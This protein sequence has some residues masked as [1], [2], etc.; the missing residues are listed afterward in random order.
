MGMVLGK[1]LSSSSILFG[2][3]VASWA[4]LRRGHPPAL[5]SARLRSSIQQ[6]MKSAR[7]SSAGPS[8]F[9]ALLHLVLQGGSAVMK[10]RLPLIY[11]LSAGN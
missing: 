10:V 6:R 5:L 8:G 11:R 1:G 3:S 2:A 9:T 7:T 4:A